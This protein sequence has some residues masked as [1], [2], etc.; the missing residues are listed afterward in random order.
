MEKRSIFNILAAIS[1]AVALLP[2]TSGGS[3]ASQATTE[4]TQ[5]MAKPDLRIILRAQGGNTQPLYIPPPDEFAKLGAQSAN[6]VINWRTDG[7]CEPWPTDAQ[8]AFQYA[9]SIWQ[10]LVN[11]PVPIVVDACWEDLTPYG[12]NVLGSAGAADYWYNFANAPQTD[13][14]YPVGLANALAK[15]DLSPSVADIDASFN[16]AFGDWYFGTDANTPFDKWNFASVVLHEICHG[17]GFIGTMQKSGANTA[18]W[19][20]YARSLIFDQFIQNSSGQTLIAKYPNANTIPSSN[21]LAELTGN[22]LYFSGTNAN[23]AAGGFPVK[24][25]AP[26]TWEPGSSLYHLDY[27]TYRSPNENSLMVYVLLNGDTNYDPGPIVKGV[28]KD[29]GWMIGS[30]EPTPTPTPTPAPMPTPVVKTIPPTG[31]TISAAHNTTTT[32]S[33]PSGIVA[34][35]ITVTLALTDV[36]TM[37]I[38]HKNVGHAFTIQAQRVSDGAPITTF[39]DAMTVTIDYGDANVWAMQENTLM[40]Y[41]W[42][43]G[44]WMTA[45]LTCDPSSTYNHDLIDNQFQIGLCH[46]AKFALLGRT[47][48]LFLPAVFKNRASP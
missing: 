16:S 41:K 39:S 38:T 45:T 8:T 28:F 30:G 43:S 37:P 4:H 47:D 22:S 31:G 6:F 11:S 23:A 40:M 26:S 2:A 5:Y 9:V 42:N 10:S 7:N 29:I 19:G 35:T 17:L 48:R 44:S 12:A 27:Q 34:E 14:W 15:T 18:T 25:Y 21:L 33:F 20:W 32:V 1:I 46:L 13:T 3:L 36:G 24:L